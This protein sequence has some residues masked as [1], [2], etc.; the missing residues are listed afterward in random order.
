[1]TLKARQNWTHLISKSI[2]FLMDCVFTRFLASNVSELRFFFVDLHLSSVPSSSARN[3]STACWLVTLKFWKN[4]RNVLIKHWHD[5]IALL[6]CFLF[7]FWSC[8]SFSSWTGIQNMKV[9]LCRSWL[10]AINKYSACAYKYET[11][12]KYWLIVGPA[13]QTVTQH[14]ISNIRC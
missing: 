4:T 1:M 9:E 2:L 12:T 7:S 6:T 5:M 13:L 11:L 10:I 14:Q 8:G 3:S